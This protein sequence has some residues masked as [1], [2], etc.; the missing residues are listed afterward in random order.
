M[1]NLPLDTIPGSPSPAGIVPATPFPARHS[2]RP[3]PIPF[4]SRART[5]HEGGNMAQAVIIFGST[6]GNT[7]YVATFIQKELESQS[8][9]V[10]LLNAADASADELKTHYDIYLLGCSTWGTDAV[11]LQEDFEDFY[12]S[13]LGGIDLSGKSFALF[14]CGDS[15]FEHFCGAVDAI[16]EQVDRLGGSLLLEPLKIDGDPDDGQLQEWMDELTS[17]L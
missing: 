12:Q 10:T 15:A 11:E 17:T 9:T 6:T 4:P 7:E 8:H 1:L 16:E 2:P 13:L 3:A 14:G 5:K